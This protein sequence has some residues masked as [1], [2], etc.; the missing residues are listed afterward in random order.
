MR[1]FL[2]T[3]EIAIGAKAMKLEFNDTVFFSF[4]KEVEAIYFLLN[5]P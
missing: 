5:I 2:G 1:D 3:N 4:K